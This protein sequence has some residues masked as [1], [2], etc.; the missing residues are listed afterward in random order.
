MTPI[1]SRRQFLGAAG[2]AV[3]LASSPSMARS[4]ASPSRRVTLGIMG[5]KRGMEVAAALENQPDVVIKYVCDVDSRRA[6]EAK[7]KL[8]R[9][10]PQRPQAITDFRR[11]LD[12]KDVDALFCEA[13]NHW[14]GPATILACEAGKHV[15]VE[16]PCSHNPWEGERMVA[17]APKRDRAVQMGS[18]RRSTPG[19]IEAMNKLHEGVIGNVY[20]ARGWYNNGRPSV[21]TG[22]P[23]SPPSTLDYELWQGPAPRTPYLDN[24]IHYN[25]HW[26]WHWGNGEL[27][28]NGIH[29]LDLCRWGLNVDYP[30][31][32]TSSGGRYRF[33]DD[34]Q[35]PDT[36]VATFEFPGGKQIC[37]QGLSCNKHA[38]SSGFVSFYGDKGS[39]TLGLF[40]DYKIHDAEDR[41]IEERSDDAGGKNPWLAID[42][43]HTAHFIDAIRNGDHFGLSAQIEKGHKS[44]LLCHLGNVAY[45]TRRTL[46][47]DPR[48]GHVLDD[49]EAMSFWR[50]EYEPGWE[51]VV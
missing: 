34:Q 17:A 8:E 3:A 50:R 7:S 31:L 30:T 21:G 38:D 1:P 2:T 51:P 48:N 47:C 26:F 5:L 14:H 44:T 13:P 10:G 45:R 46:Q 4:S 25:W 41:L 36:Q 24:R 20:C 18:Q 37:W 19:V 9:S 23:T 39:L 22:K 35:T 40:G 12:D 49:P 43:F 33:Q 16:K 42:T 15:Y 28:N 29:S 27:G 11:I 6:E 32:V